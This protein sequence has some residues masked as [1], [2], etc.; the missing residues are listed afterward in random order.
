M[1]PV[2][3]KSLNSLV[4]N[5]SVSSSSIIKKRSSKKNDAEFKK[6]SVSSM[7]SN[8]LD[9]RN[10]PLTILEPEHKL[11]SFA[12]KENDHLF[13]PISLDSGSSSVM[14]CS[15]SYRSIGFNSH[16]SIQ[17]D[18]DGDYTSRKKKEGYYIRSVISELSAR[19][20]S[21][22]YVPKI[23]K[24]VDLTGSN[25][26]WN[27]EV[28]YNKSPL[29]LNKISSNTRLDPIPYREELNSLNN[30]NESSLIRPKINII[31]CHHP[32][33]LIL[34]CADERI[35]KRNMAIQVKGIVDN[36]KIKR[37]EA[38]IEHKLS[39]PQRYEVIKQ[40]KVRQLAW[41]QIIFSAAFIN[42]LEP[43]FGLKKMMLDMFHQKKE[44]SVIVGNFM[45]RWN[46]KRLFIKYR[47][48]FKKAIQANKAN[49][50]MKIRIFRKRRALR[51]LKLFIKD[52]TASARMTAAI[53]NFLKSIRL[54]QKNIRGFLQCQRSRLQ[55]L[56][57]IWDKYELKYIRKK[58]EDRKNHG[59]KTAKKTKIVKNPE[60][61]EES[62]EKKSQDRKDLK[63][64]LL[65]DKQNEKWH[66]IDQRMEAEIA[67]QKLLGNLVVETGMEIVTKM[68][69]SDHTKNAAILELFRRARKAHILHCEEMKAFRNSRLS[70]SSLF[71]LYFS[72]KS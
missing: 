1:I 12:K 39:R 62:E 38:N 60:I 61:V 72:K 52:M 51:I 8:V 54:I 9:N 70:V 7:L 49:F 68:F 23:Q 55:V 46:R 27:S 24:L 59:L 31:G 64:K 18:G 50:I 21:N 3:S 40:H 41:I 35:R 63:S 14:D 15:M 56:T 37:V 33:D 32:I 57:K 10:S 36:Y 69:I 43:I 20:N 66:I 29:N 71:L 16:R 13:P 45:L 19:S 30:D 26:S 6:A 5:N 17:Y 44:K 58:L 48:A 22:S 67:K 11:E 53:R 65:M 34:A 28:S 2:M 47:E 4:D 25:L 42:K